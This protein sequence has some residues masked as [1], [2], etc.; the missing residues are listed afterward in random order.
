MS[1]GY[2]AKDLRSIR[3]I[4]DGFYDLFEHFCI[5]N[6]EG[7]DEINFIN[8][9]GGRQVAR[10]SGPYS[11]LLADFNSSVLNHTDYAQRRRYG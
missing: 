11:Q 8:L 7:V 2:P 9:S 3:H 5:V 6:H 4:P 10:S 1:S